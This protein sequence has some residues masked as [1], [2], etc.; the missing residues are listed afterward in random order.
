MRFLADLG[1]NRAPASPAF[2]PMVEVVMVEVVTS[3]AASGHGTIVPPASSYRFALF[4]LFFGLACS[5]TPAA[6]PTPHAAGTSALAGT[7][8]AA[9]AGVGE[10]RP[11]GAGAPTTAG[12]RGLGNRWQRRRQWQRERWRELGCCRRGHDRHHLRAVQRRATART[13]NRD[14]TARHPRRP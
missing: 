10:Q 6:E 12:N 9:T 2:T 5:S 8:G 13:I 14:R 3:G 1:Q 7:G 11:G 4:T